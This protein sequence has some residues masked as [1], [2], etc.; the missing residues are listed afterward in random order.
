MRARWLIGGG[1]ALIGGTLWWLRRDAPAADR[2]L[3]A[4]EVQDLYG[5]LARAYDRLATVYRLVGTRE[6]ARRGIGLLGLDAGDTVVDLGCGT[7]INLP[8]LSRAVGP[9]GRVI[10]VDLTAEMLGRARSRVAA[11]GLDNVD[12]VRADVRQWALPDDVRGIVSAFALEM[13]PEYDDVVARACEA[14]AANG[15]RIAVMG[16]R[17]PPNCPRWAVTLGIAVTRPFGVSRAYTHMRPWEAVRRHAEEVHHET[18]L[19]GAVYLSV[20]APR[21]RDR[22]RS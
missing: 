2:V 18:M 11:E 14:L 16:L 9:E 21:T 12:L 22:A 19:F 7:G 20:G 3:D 17:E 8:D 1:A 5:R 10:G 13:V 15:G 4:R 6:L